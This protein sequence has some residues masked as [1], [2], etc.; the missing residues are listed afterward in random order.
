MMLS[1]AV[2][3]IVGPVGS[4]KTSRR[5]VQ[6]MLSGAMELA[7]GPTGSMQT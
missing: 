4:L 7:A 5:Q 1:K 6:K 3:P 2:E